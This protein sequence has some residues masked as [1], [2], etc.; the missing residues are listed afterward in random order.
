MKGKEK[1][2]Y[3]CS[4]LESI[5]LPDGVTSIEKETFNGC[6][7][8]KSITIPNTVTEIKEKAFY[9]FQKN[10]ISGGRCPD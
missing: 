2:F 8:L 5:V 9:G 10:G 7:S 4:S 1:T 6:S 3:G